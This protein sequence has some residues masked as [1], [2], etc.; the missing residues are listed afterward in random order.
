[1][2]EV[3]RGGVAC[4]T[5]TGELEINGISLHMAPAWCTSTLLN[6]WMTADVKG[7]GFVE[8]PDAHGG[9][10]YRQ[11]DA[12]TKRTMP[13]ALSGRYA[14][15]GDEYDD[16]W[17]GLQTNVNY[18]RENLFDMRDGSGLSVPS[19]EATLTMPDG[20]ERFA[21]VRVGNWQFG[22]NVQAVTK[23]SFDLTIISGSFRTDT[24]SA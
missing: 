16:E 3:Q 17:T 1:V 10:A 15:N 19:W 11:L 20:E 12:V 5:A 8:Q 14:W 6:L 24:E 18:L 9:W 22:E 2:N 21:T 7:A 4:S 23:T 13:L